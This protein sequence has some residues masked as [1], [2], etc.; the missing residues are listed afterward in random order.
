M[1]DQKQSLDESFHFNN[2]LELKIRYDKE[3]LTKEDF[4]KMQMNISSLVNHRRYKL[5][6]DGVFS[7]IHHWLNEVILNSQLNEDMK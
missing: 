5:G 4:G 1:Y 2:Q 7:E 3:R 6:E